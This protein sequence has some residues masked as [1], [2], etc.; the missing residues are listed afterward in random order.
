MNKMNVY[1]YI[2][3][4]CTAA[5]LWRTDHSDE[6]LKEN[7][8]IYISHHFLSLFS[9]ENVNSSAAE[10]GVIVKIPPSDIIVLLLHAMATL[11]AVF[12]T[13]FC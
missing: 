1:L 13:Y 11:E 6:I 5:E 2:S 7:I 9:T 12:Y 3:M 10:C 4:H 8:Y